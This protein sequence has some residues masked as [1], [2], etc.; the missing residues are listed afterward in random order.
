MKKQ[1]VTTLQN[2]LHQAKAQGSTSPRNLDNR[3]M[4]ELERRIQA[5]ENEEQVQVNQIRQAEV[6]AQFELQ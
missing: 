4:M 5:A 3:V 2:E 1:Q 6:A